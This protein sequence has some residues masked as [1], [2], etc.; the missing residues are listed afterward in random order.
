MKLKYILIIFILVELLAISVICLNDKNDNI[1]DLS[2]V[3]TNTN[4]YILIHDSKDYYKEEY[5]NKIKII[6]DTDKDV[7]FTSIEKIPNI[8]ENNPLS[9]KYYIENN[10][11]YTLNPINENYTLES[12]LDFDKNGTYKIQRILQIGFPGNTAEF[13]GLN[14]DDEAYI[15]TQLAIWNMAMITNEYGKDNINSESRYIAIL[16]EKYNE[17]SINNKVFDV[18]KELVNRSESYEDKEINSFNVEYENVKLVETNIDKY[19][20][21]GPFIFRNTTAVYNVNTVHIANSLE[22]TLP[23]FVV[24][25]YGNSVDY[26]END[27]EYYIQVG[28]SNDMVNAICK[29]TFYKPISHIF[30]CKNNKFI[31]LTTV[32]NESERVIPIYNNQ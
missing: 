11:S 16:K 17:R 22:Y 3:K 18:A 28:T 26:P 5:K 13:L 19:K 6:N 15:A 29:S 7:E 12:N 30:N 10:V 21:Y 31:Y 20:T 24:D 2:K 14:N 1:I 8:S 25:E 32:K 27:K 9:N 23:G 4:N